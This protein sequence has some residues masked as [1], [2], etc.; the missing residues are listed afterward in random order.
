MDPAVI[1]AAVM[2]VLIMV[3]AVIFA[4][5]ALKSKSV[6][7]F[8]F[9]FSIFMLIWAAAEIPAVLSGAGVLVTTAYQN[10]GLEVHLISM[11]IFGGFVVF[12]GR[13]IF[14]QLRL[15]QIIEK[16][17]YSSVSMS[18][19]EEG[20]KALGFYVDYGLAGKDPK[21]FDSMLRKV[22]ASGSDIIEKNIVEELYRLSGVAKV[23]GTDPDFVTAVNKV[24]ASAS[25]I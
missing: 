9:Q 17:T 13:N 24:A 10:L 18:I 4:A 23:D 1:G 21:Q 12:R 16:A 11:F 25:K 2:G 8:S 20:A 22:F 15:G 6:K 7:S 5:L 14:G 3:S 19:N